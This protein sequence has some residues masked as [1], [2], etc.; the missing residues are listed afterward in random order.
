MNEEAKP[1]NYKEQLENELKQKFPGIQEK[2][3][4]LTNELGPALYDHIRNQS[5]QEILNGYSG[6]TDAPFR[7]Y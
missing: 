1:Y 2:W 5:H 3:E 6:D 4:S 7:A